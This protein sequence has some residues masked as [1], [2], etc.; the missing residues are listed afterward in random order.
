VRRWH[1]HPLRINT[2]L[3]AVRFVIRADAP[4][5]RPRDEAAGHVPVPSAGGQGFV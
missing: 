5:L 4:L 2:P 3:R 1:D